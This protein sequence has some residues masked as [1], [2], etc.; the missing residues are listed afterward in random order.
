MQLP[1]LKQQLQQTPDTLTGIIA[2]FNNHT[3]NQSTE[4]SGWTAGQVTDHLIKACDIATVLEGNVK[5]AD[6]DP[7][8]LSAGI[9]NAFLDFSIKMNSP[10]FILPGNGPFDP[11]QSIQT[12][13]NI[14]QTLRLKAEQLDLSA[15]CLDFE[16]PVN[17][18]LTRQEWLSFVVV[19]TQRHIHQ[20]R[21]IAGE[22]HI[23]L[24]ATA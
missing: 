11:Q 4:V 14:W 17:G 15:L 23:S 8:A 13:T 1:T 2:A 6:R 3:F 16:M 22:L 10:D 12:L 19:H 5:S 7:D 24:P 9:A 20:L 18:A 21:K